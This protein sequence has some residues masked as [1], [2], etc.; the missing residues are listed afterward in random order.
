M[1]LKYEERAKRVIKGKEEIK[2]SS[3]SGFHLVILKGRA[4]S[5]KQVSGSA[6]D[7][8]ELTI[9]IDDKTFPKLGSSSKK[10]LDSPAAI[11]GGRSHNL[12]KTVHFLTT[13]F[14]KDHKIIL[15]TDDPTATATL[16]S[17]E[18]YTFHLT[19]AFTLEPKLQAEDGD[20]REWTTFVL[21]NLPLN[22][23]TAE[24]NLKRRFLD[25]DDVKVIVDGQIKRND[26]SILHKLWYFAASIL[27]G[28][29]QTETFS[30]NLSTGLHY[31]EFWADRMPTIDK[32]TF[33]FGSSPS[34][35]I[36]TVDDPKWT[37]DF[38]DD[39]DQ[40]ILARA[41]FG[42]ARSEKLPDEARIAVGW[43]IKNR[44]EDSRWPNTYQ[45]V[46]TQ[47]QQYSAF[48]ATD[49]NRKYVENP[50]WTE[51]DID[52]K[53]WYNCFD[54]AGKVISGE[55]KDSANGANH[56]Y[57]SSITAPYW[58]TKETLV[59][60]INDVDNNPTLFFHKL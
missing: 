57:D 26:R 48:N 20:R 30:V 38:A 17:L 13:L 58:A 41:I 11:N 56:Y 22:S 5:E 32:I 3:G 1:L 51:S 33:N 14:G 60:T 49:P 54:I 16:E 15:K 28:E 50:F 12:S 24:L 7:D 43:S 47:D 46:I 59:L 8:E 2:F 29:I 23:F 52:K 37:G 53:A 39:S 31:I 36:P 35:R 44:V 19:D 21:D 27:T 42:E 45:E 4:K 34:K 9:Q 18:V 6:T 25:S 10:V 40:I 55:L